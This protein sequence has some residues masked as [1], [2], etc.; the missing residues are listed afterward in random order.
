MP[1]CLIHFNFCAFGALQLAEYHSQRCKLFVLRKIENAPKRFERTNNRWAQIAAP[2]C[3]SS[4]PIFVAKCGADYLVSVVRNYRSKLGCL[5]FA[6]SKTVG[7]SSIACN[8]I[9]NH[10]TIKL[11]KCKTLGLDILKSKVSEKPNF[12]HISWL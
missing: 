6:N 2:D 3:N 11:I 7:G 1:D 8:V 5:V 9:C 4:V 10:Q 12:S